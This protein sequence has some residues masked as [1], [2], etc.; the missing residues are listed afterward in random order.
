MIGKKIKKFYNKG[1]DL[2]SLHGIYITVWLVTIFLYSLHIVGYYGRFRWGGKLSIFIFASLFAMFL[3]GLN[4]NRSGYSS[5][6]VDFNALFNDYTIVFI[7]KKVNYLFWFW[8]CGN[9][10]T[11]IIQGG[12][13]M[14]W[15]ALGIPKTYVDYGL[16]TF[17]GFLNSMFYLCGLTYFAVLLKKR[18][19]RVIIR[20][21]VLAIFPILT[22]NRALFLILVLQCMGFFL[23]TNKIKVKTLI[24]I[25]ILML[26]LIIGFGMIGDMRLGENSHI[27]RDLVSDEYSGIREKMPSGFIWTYLYATGTIDNLNYNI[28]NIDVVGYPYYTIQPL[29]PSVLRPIIFGVTEYENSYSLKMSNEMFNTFSWLANFL[30]DFGTTITVVVVFLYGLLFRRV[31]NKARKGNI[32]YIFLYPIMFMVVVISVFWDYMISLPTIFEIIIVCMIYN[33]RVT[34]LIDDKAEQFFAIR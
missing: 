12:F 6:R 3:S 21:L 20:F 2:S 13:P 33:S 10:I 28:G 15:L 34:K 26:I 29:I 19:Q 7:T 1:L 11:V 9:I 25:V 24:R 27:I 23:L 30:R 32:K 5:R 22:I 18:S 17:N 14:L 4:V 31:Q 8:V 16:P